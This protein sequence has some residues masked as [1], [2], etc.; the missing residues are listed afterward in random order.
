MPEWPAW[1]SGSDANMKKFL[2]ILFFLSIPSLVWAQYIIPFG[3]TV[4]STKLPLSGGT[5]TGDLTVTGKT[6]A[7]T[8]AKFSFLSDGYIPYYSST[9]GIT[10]S[11][12]FQLNGNVG[13]GTMNPSGKLDIRDG[14]LRLTD[15]DVAHGLTG[16][17]STETYADMGVIDATGGGLVL[18]GFSDN[19]AITGLEIAGFIGVADPTDST[20]AVEISGAK[21]NGTGQAALGDL[22]TILAVTNAV[23]Q[24]HGGSA[25]KLVVLGSGNVGIGTTSLPGTPK[26]GVN[27]T[28]GTYGLATDASN[29]QMGTLSAS[30]GNGTLGST[31]LSCVR[32]GTGAVNCDIN[33]TP[34]GTGSVVI[35]AGANILYRCVGGTGDGLISVNNANASCPVGTWTATSL[36][37]N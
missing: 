15:A 16:W 37:I 8:S 12:M 9:A 27:G 20:P 22:E 29:Y 31:T 35:N 5:I 28:I 2:F 24:P 17:V 7:T 10:N 23:N 33:L 21:K 30:N 34:L 19:A 13:I 3:G 4:D 18:R 6:T 26:L 32:A 36:K 14:N 1:P 25:T 11:A